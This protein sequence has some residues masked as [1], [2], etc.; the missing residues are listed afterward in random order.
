MQKKQALHKQKFELALW[1][2]ASVV[3]ASYNF[4]V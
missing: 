3:A 1:L 2:A 4:L